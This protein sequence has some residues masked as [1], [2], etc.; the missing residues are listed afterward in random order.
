MKTT[1]TKS[2]TTL[3]CALALMLVMYNCKKKDEPFPTEPPKE[4]VDKINDIEITP[5]TATPP[6]PVATTP[7]GV[8]ASPEA[9]A[10]SN[11]L[12]DMATTGV[13]PASITATGAAVSAAI[14]AADLAI[15]SAI[16]PETLASVKAG[17]AL[18]PAAQAA[19]DK[20][21]TNPAIAALLP[22]FT[23]PT[24]GGQVVNGR[25]AAVGGT[26]TTATTD[27]L[28]SG[29][30]IEAVLVDD[31]CIASAE[32]AFQTVKTKLDAAR[33]AENLKVQTTYSTTI[34]PYA[35][36]V[37][38]C[39]AAVN[40]T[41]QRTAIDTQVAQALANLETARA[42]L[43]AAGLYDVFVSLINVQAAGAYIGINNL[44]AAD[45]AACTALSTAKTASAAAARDTDLAKVQ[46]EYSTKLAAATAVKAEL[47]A[48]CH[49]QGGGN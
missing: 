22:K 17:G 5:I 31:A 9:A 14:P 3:L 36:E 33:D 40:Y 12:N 10:L 48:S 23:Y 27:V 1:K 21:L 46:A 47:I 49:N 45:K 29:E 19:V 16:S 18:S 35:A 43:T 32:N 20:A 7:A 6:A 15:L 26:T 34:A 38:A 37:T 41:A 44:E 8:T 24:V 28:E 25:V 42:I 13:I 4:L 39:Q 2:I 11:A 30:A